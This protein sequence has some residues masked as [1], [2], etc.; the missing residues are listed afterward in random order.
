ML[1]LGLVIQSLDKLVLI[2]DGVLG[3]SNSLGVDD[4][5]KEWVS[6]D[7]V[8]IVILVIRII[9]NEI[10]LLDLLVPD[11]EISNDLSGMGRFLIF[12]LLFFDSDVDTVSTQVLVSQT[13][14]VSTIS[15]LHSS[16]DAWLNLVE[17][18]VLKAE[19][20]SDVGDRVLGNSSEPLSGVIFGDTPSDPRDLFS[21]EKFL[22]QKL[23]LRL[24]F[25]LESFVVHVSHSSDVGGFVFESGDLRE[26]DW[27]FFAWVGT[28]VHDFLPSLIGVGF[29][30]DNPSSV[31]KLVSSGLDNH[32]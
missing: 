6:L 11:G 13:G 32:E 30:S 5:I 18:G 19:C 28:F 17:L 2:F 25:D 15:S 27:S 23:L 12:G 9:F 7:V 24:D 26:H 4:G 21:G 8:L 29:T 14:W 10:F 22:V 3:E 31:G 20:L 16:E 1:G